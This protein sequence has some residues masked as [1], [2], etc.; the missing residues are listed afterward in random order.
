M[1]LYLRKNN[2]K[3]ELPIALKRTLW[4]IHLIKKS[5]QIRISY[6]PI[7]VEKDNTCPMTKVS[8]KSSPKSNKRSTIPKNRKYPK[9]GQEL[10]N[11]PIHQSQIKY[12]QIQRQLSIH[13]KLRKFCSINLLSNIWKTTSMPIWLETEIKKKKSMNSWKRR[14]VQIDFHKSIPAKPLKG[15][16]QITKKEINLKVS[17]WGLKTIMFS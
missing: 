4:S 9:E 11:W 5:D 12:S 2:L 17:K 15:K 16:F 8:M 10:E 7:L 13:K 3:E 1:N 14:K 6:R